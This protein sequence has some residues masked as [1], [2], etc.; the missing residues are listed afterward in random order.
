MAGAYAAQ[1]QRPGHGGKEGTARV[2][3]TSGQRVDSAREEGGG[4]EGW[5]RWGRGEPRGRARTSA[6]FERCSSVFSKAQAKSRGPKAER[7][8]LGF[9]AHQKGPSS[10]RYEVLS[11]CQGARLQ[12]WASGLTAFSGGPATERNPVQS[13]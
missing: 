5:V 3:S 9:L 6:N 8:G 13:K 2:N 10:P 7:G 4:G 11:A 12:R 1:C